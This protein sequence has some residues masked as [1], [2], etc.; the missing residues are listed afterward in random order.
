MDVQTPRL[1]PIVSSGVEQSGNPPTEMAAGT[2][3]EYESMNGQEAGGQPIGKSKIGFSGRKDES[4]HLS[5]FTL[6]CSQAEH[7][8]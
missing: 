5:T 2:A 1:T 3:S 6:Q 4:E 8:F 7:A